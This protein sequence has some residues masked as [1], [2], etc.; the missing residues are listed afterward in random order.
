MELCMSLLGVLF[1]QRPHEVGAGLTEPRL[2][3]E[4]PDALS[5]VSV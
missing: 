5:R 4:L 1:R 3:Y 2:Y